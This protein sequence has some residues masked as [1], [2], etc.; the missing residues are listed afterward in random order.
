MRRDFA[1]GVRDELRV[2]GRA[3]VLIFAAGAYA[4]LLLTAAR[5]FTAM[6]FR[7][8]VYAFRSLRKTPGFS[9]VI[10][11]TLALAIGAN[12]TI[13]SIVRAV[14]LAP[15]PYAQSER[16]VALEG[17]VQGRPFSLSLPDFYDLRA[18]S[19]EFAAMAAYSSNAQILAGLGEPRKVSGTIAT[20]DLF[21][22]LGTRPELGR[23]FND[24]D[25]RSGAAKVVVV[26]DDFWRTAM[27]ADPQAIGRDVL[28]SGDAY[29]VIGVAPPGFQQPL[30]HRGFARSQY[31]LVL[32]AVVTGSNEYSRGAHY[33][34]GVGRLRDGASVAGAG[35]EL[36]TI[37]ARLAIAHP[38]DDKRFGVATIGLYDELVGDV[39]PLLFAAFAAVAG[40]LLV[41]CA[42]VAN[43]L[44]SRAATR[45][46]ELA[47]RVA[48][49][50]SRG[51]IVAQLLTETFALALA[52]G[53]LGAA[54]AALAVR[55]FVAL[56]PPGIP[57]IGDVSF[58]GAAVLYTLA[59]V[60]IATFAAGAA[61]AFAL[62]NRNVAASLK[63]AGRSGD[64][65]A[66]RRLRG[67]LV[68]SEIALTLALVVAAGL[69]VRSFVHLTG[70][71]LGFDAGGIRAIGQV[72]LPDRRYGTD[73]ALQ[74]A[75]FARG[76]ERVRA[77]PGVSDAAWSCC[78]PF[79]DQDFSL[80]FDIVG[81]P[82]PAG[83]S[84]SAL[85]N[86]VTSDYFKLFR[87]PI[88]SGRAFADTDR[89][90]S[91]KV[92]IVN[93]AFAKRYFPGGSPLG[94]RITW[95]G[96]PPPGSTQY[97]RTIVGVAGD[98]RDSYAK[99]Q[100]PLIYLPDAQEPYSSETL[101]V[102]ADSSAALAAAAAVA[103]VDPS[104]PKPPVTLFATYLERDS[105]RARVSAL[106]LGALAIIALGLSIAGIFAVVSYGVAQRTHEFG[107]RMALG[108]RAANIVRG[109]VGG[110]MRT[111]LVG[112]LLGLVLAG[113]GTRFLADQLYD[114]A[115]LDP[116]TFGAV[117]LLIG[118]TTLAASFVPARR[119][120][121]VD[122]VVALRY[123]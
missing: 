112:V 19:H 115:P 85:N 114:T 84:P 120:T 100:L 121:Q 107:I 82:A 62:S 20:S 99:P 113:A 28:L 12:A 49:G 83:E 50:A 34:D 38:A 18:A 77:I 47:V 119:A 118:F 116:L 89:A 35:E 87:I 40:V 23:F 117:T 29:R 21:A 86:L 52:G 5:E 94:A 65:S 39:R 42:N 7:D 61:P 105:A 71:S 48:I 54:G 90:G 2:H 72:D 122:P 37:F 59:V 3:A 27:H 103:G 55:A 33:F 91:P 9:S 45:D 98:V 16:L 36:S 75:Y 64:A 106:T 81:R 46:R 78:A 60:A 68:I 8:L 76:L 15:L 66:G 95:G 11:A 13:F 92:V 56:D 80:D 123:E 22:T 108:A 102:R 93:E 1:D 53:I 101:Y 79:S 10:V 67:A 97:D 4:D 111:A 109:V 25:A 57:R 26:S 58:D 14:V 41:A 104:L 6:F 63:A 70:E 74:A 31:W 30:F 88:L 69:V 51:R 110:A 32:P 24:A 44:L 96:T 17:R 73:A 43:L